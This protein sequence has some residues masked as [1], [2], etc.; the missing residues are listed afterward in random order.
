MTENKNKVTNGESG[1]TANNQNKSVS[2]EKPKAPDDGVG[3]SSRLV[4][5]SSSN[6]GP[7]NV[8]HYLLSKYLL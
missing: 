2:K 3:V 8:G 4:K 1:G 7:R 5:S 6:L